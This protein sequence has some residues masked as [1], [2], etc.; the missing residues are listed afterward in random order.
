MP[1]PILIVAYY[2]PPLMASGTLR[3]TSFVSH[4]SRR[5]GFRP[6]VLTSEPGPGETVDPE[7]ETRIPVASV[8]LRAR[9]LRLDLERWRRRGGKSGEGSRGGGDGPGSPLPT[10]RM[11]RT[12]DLLSW[13]LRF[14]DKK[15]GWLLP[16]LLAGLRAV[17]REAPAAI[18]SS[19]PPHTGHLV[20]ALLSR[21]SGAPLVADFRDPW[22]GNPFNPLPYESLRRA[23][24]A[25]ERFVLRTAR[26]VVTVTGEQ[27]MALLR[28]HPGLDPAR[29]LVI[30]N[31]FDRE[32]LPAP[33][34]EARGGERLEI[35][36]AGLLYGKRDPRPF[37][38][39][40]QALL[41]ETPE[42]R[43]RLRVVFLG[44]GDDPA[45]S[46]RI[47]RQ[48]IDDDGVLEFEPAVGHK[49]ALGRMASA[50]ALLLLGPLGD[51]PELQ[52]PAKLYEYLGVGR[53][54]LVLSHR[55]GAIGGIL[56]GISDR[57]YRA[58][59]HDV[60]GIQRALQDLFRDREQDRR[61]GTTRK[62]EPPSRFDR[63]LLAQRLGAV[64]EAVISGSTPGL[65]F[66]KGEGDGE[67]SWREPRSCRS[68]TEAGPRGN[69]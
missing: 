46:P 25:L 49:E 34:E 17:S 62:W 53:R 58:E 59:P 11:G 27:R 64:L 26:A 37:L 33:V 45:Y 32:T 19:G 50:G 12:R 40:I 41:V 8:V 51:E 3:T 39:A 29:V 57:I 28:G 22:A 7:L 10:S 38:R 31:G 68:G 5:L 18:F 4:L 13:L 9:R 48:V 60:A 67:V 21:F 55:L 20:A 23:E 42:L 61:S 66:S 52:V 2:Y 30:T 24:Q 35:L 63:S 69:S 65:S 15:V 56:E 47:L 36:H 14:P 43:T 1:R 6:T 44:A 54:L 16:A